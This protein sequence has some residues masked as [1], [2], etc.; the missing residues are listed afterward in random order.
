MHKHRIWVLCPDNDEPVGGIRKLYRLVDVLN[1]NGWQSSIIHRKRD[2]R[3]SWFE[4]STQ[5]IYW[6]DADIELT[7]ILVLPEIFGPHLARLA[8][9]TPK[10]LFN[11]NS[12]Y[13][14]CGYSLDRGD[15]ET[16]YKH[17]DVV[18]VLVVSE[19]N[20]DYL[21]Y[22][23]P[24]AKITR[25]RLGIDD[26][27]FFPGEKKPTM[28]F[29]PRKNSDDV[30]QVIN[31]LKQRRALRDFSL[32]PI[33]GKS[34]WE[35]AA[36]MSEAPLFLSFGHPEG[37]S[38][39]PLEAMASGCFVIGYH[40]NGGREFFRPAFSHPIAVGDILGFAQTVEATIAAY[41]ANPALIHDK[42]L[43]A[44]QFVREHYSLKRE[45]EGI[46][47]FW[48]EMDRLLS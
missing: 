37:L 10:V 6:D 42:G 40:G 15:L 16:P 30:L 21:A 14:F 29:M 20:H 28:A 33:H 41:A 18:A 13:T 27:L 45:E 39:P 35:T 5:T 11:Q 22:A 36:I 25:L 17:P 34:E 8:P 9:G 32:V 47:R 12:Y 46:V 31:L 38:L 3:C 26:A 43:M 24:R 1:R 7:D 19:D 48:T 44:S 23:F 2:F 4:N